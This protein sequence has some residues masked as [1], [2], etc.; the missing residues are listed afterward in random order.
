MAETFYDW[1]RTARGMLALAA[2]YSV[3]VYLIPKPV[4]VKPEGWR[5]T[6]LFIATIAGCILQPIP[7]GAL[8]LLAVTL[9][10]VIGGLTIEQALMGYAD[11]AVWLV[12]AAF[13][14]SRALVNS[15][16]ARRIALFF[17]KVFGK[18][19]LGVA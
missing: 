11:K 5:L 13:F 2:V 10:S 15:G 14:I 1:K 6:G 8:V 7:S 4:A 19:S 9:S 16:L 18:S 3:V 12:M 17:V